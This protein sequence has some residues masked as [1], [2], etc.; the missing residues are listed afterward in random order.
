[1][2]LFRRLNPQTNPP[3]RFVAFSSWVAQKLIRRV[4]EYANLPSANY[5]DYGTGILKANIPQLLNKTDSFVLE[6]DGTHCARPVKY[7]YIT[8]GASSGQWSNCVFF[9]LLYF[10]FFFQISLF[11]HD[12]RR[13][14]GLNSWQATELKNFW[15]IN[16]S[17]RL[18]Y[19]LNWEGKKLLFSKLG[20]WPTESVRQWALLDRN[21]YVSTLIA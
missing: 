3:D 14:L 15:L 13:W 17:S 10:V 20:D 19:L 11:K 18:L 5:Q 9:L 7:N 4:Y 2:I 1:M 21:V 8:T 16:L 12:L 6:Y